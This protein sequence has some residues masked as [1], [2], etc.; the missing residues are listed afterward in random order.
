MKILDAFLNHARTDVRTRYRRV[1][2]RLYL[3][4]L[5][6]D[7]HSELSAYNEHGHN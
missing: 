7:A 3:Q 2:I 6:Q 1:R 4:A 5:V